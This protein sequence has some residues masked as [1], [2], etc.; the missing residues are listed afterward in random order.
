MDCIFCKIAK[1]EIP[2]AKVYETDKVVAFRDLN[3][4]APLHVLI[5][6][7]EHIASLNELTEQQAGVMAEIALAARI[8]AA[9][10]GVSADG[11]R[12][13]NNCGPGAGQTVMHLHFHLLG[14]RDFS[15]PPG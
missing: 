12:L 2:A 3:P 9:Q 11:Y 4:V 6:P 8:I 15:W 10:E 14:G 7:K 1:G 5:I 13:V